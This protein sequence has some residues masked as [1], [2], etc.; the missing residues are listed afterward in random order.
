MEC[1]FETIT[2]DIWNGVNEVHTWNS[3]IDFSKKIDDLTENIDIIHVILFFMRH[4]GT[5][6][7][8]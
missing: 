2:K 1:D 7:T 5:V 8:G 3:N 4:F 6:T